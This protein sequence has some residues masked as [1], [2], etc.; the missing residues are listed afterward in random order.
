M[1]SEYSTCLIFFLAPL[2]PIGTKLGKHKLRR[3]GL[4]GANGAAA[5]PAGNTSYYVC[6]V[7]VCD[8]L[9]SYVLLMLIAWYYKCYKCEAAVIH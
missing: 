9:C 4:L 5:H 7:D 3:N 6:F 2:Q 1:L 8:S